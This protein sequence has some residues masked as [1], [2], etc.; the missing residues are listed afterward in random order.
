MLEL[1]L[2][3]INFKTSL[4]LRGKKHDWRDVKFG[5]LCRNQRLIIS[6]DPNKSS[7]RP[8]ILFL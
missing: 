7:P 2:W 6:P 1:L 5:A 4:S 3:K 8:Y